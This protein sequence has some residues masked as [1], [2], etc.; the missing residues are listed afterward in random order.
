MFGSRSWEP[1]TH[2]AWAPRD[3]AL[4]PC[5]WGDSSRVQATTPKTGSGGRLGDGRLAGHRAAPLPGQQARVAAELDEQLP[6]AELAG[7][8]H[9]AEG[10]VSV[11]AGVVGDTGGPQLREA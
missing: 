6:L 1:A 11:A 9:L 7:L 2:L 3:G 10:L 4:G 8:H 5:S